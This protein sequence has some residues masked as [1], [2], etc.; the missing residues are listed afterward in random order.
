ML[1]QLWNDF[2]IYNK[3]I[4]KCTY[5][6][7]FQDIGRAFGLV[8]KKKTDLGPIINAP[9]PPS[10]LTG[11]PTG[12]ALNERILAGLKG[13]GVG[14]SQ[15]GFDPSFVSKTTS[16]VVAQREAR[17]RRTE[18]PQAEASF[19]ARG[20][21]RSTIA[22]KEIGEITGQKERDIDQ[23][24]AS[25]F[26]QNEQQKKIDEQVRA[27]EA[28]GFRGEAFNFAGAETGLQSGVAAEQSRRAGISVGAEQARNIGQQADI[29]RLIGT[30]IGIFNPQAGQIFAGGTGGTQ[31]GFD[32][33]SLLREQKRRQETP[34]PSPF[35]GG[36]A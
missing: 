5:G 34:Q 6:G 11:V 30:G 23:L 1:R 26:L 36:G 18:R 25:A 22:G 9:L 29:N 33:Q 27:Q 15:I 14:P 16:P 2:K 12:K 13:E 28:A 3:R 10:S 24:I 17:F 32:I 7:F 31:Q 19:G 21:S 35:I 8:P 20:L 4:F